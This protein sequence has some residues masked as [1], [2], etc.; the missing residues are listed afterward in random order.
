MR[1]ANR[2]CKVCSVGAW[3]VRGARTEARHARVRLVGRT[4]D[5]VVLVGRVEANA[6]I[7]STSSPLRSEK[8]AAVS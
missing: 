3:R 8:H 2:Y 7:L 5:R 4:V 1:S 6:A